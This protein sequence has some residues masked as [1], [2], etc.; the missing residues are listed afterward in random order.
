M[1]G[2][3]LAAGMGSRL[4]PITNRV[5]KP[6]LPIANKPCIHYSIEALSESGISEIAVVTGHHA[7]LLEDA[8]T[9]DES[10]GVHLAFVR[11]PEPKGLA[12][13]VFFAR[14]FIGREPF[15]LLLGDTL[16]DMD[17]RPF[18]ERALSE[19]A[20][21]LA[22]VAPVDNPRRYGIAVLDGDRIAALEEKPA[23]PKSNLAIAGAYVFGASLWDV[24]PDLRPS[25]RGELE[26]TDA[27]QM[28]VN[29]GGKVVAERYG[30]WWQDTGTLDYM[31][32]A[33]RYW[34][35]KK[36]V[37]SALLGTGAVVTDASVRDF[38]SVGEL[39][40]IS[41]GTVRNSIVLPGIRL[42]LNG[43]TVRSCLVGVDTDLAPGEVIEHQILG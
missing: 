43:G 35:K 12:H 16:H 8:L 15:V 42:H 25:E 28:L 13:A 19:S 6:L 4:R 38:T 31:V 27:I 18:W 30:G 17:L 3:I 37:T 1:K 5:P 22:L 20:D 41:G 14:E 9:H 29:N 7:D 32:S 34:M 36:D 39:A 33:N 11:Q 40:E 2:L 26:I 10:M 24:L 23:R 21:C